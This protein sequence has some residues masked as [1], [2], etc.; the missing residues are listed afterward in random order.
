MIHLILPPDFNA[1]KSPVT[2]QIC[3]V[4][5]YDFSE[6]SEQIYAILY[7]LHICHLIKE[8]PYASPNEVLHAI[9]TVV[10]DIDLGSDELQI[11]EF[12]YIRVEFRDQ[13][14]SLEVFVGV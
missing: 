12:R 5:N 2:L 8:L 11:S 4:E 13:M 14:L 3:E 10:D 7:A 6:S 1:P 9:Q